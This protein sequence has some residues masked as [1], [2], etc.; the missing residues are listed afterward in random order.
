MTFVSC[1]QLRRNKELVV[2]FL[3]AHASANSANGIHQED[4]SIEQEVN[5]KILNVKYYKC[6][7]NAY[8]W[9]VYMQNPVSHFRKNTDEGL[10]NSPV[11]GKNGGESMKKPVWCLGLWTNASLDILCSFFTVNTKTTTRSMKKQKL[12]Y[13]EYL[14]WCEMLKI[15]IQEVVF[16]V[17]VQLLTPTL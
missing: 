6:S 1:K 2:C 9:Y 4:T 11:L 14:T 3:Q 8:V 17:T 5:G 13:E 16:K 10:R 15:S 7:F 12:H